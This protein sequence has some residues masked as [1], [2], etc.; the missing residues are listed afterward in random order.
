[1]TRKEVQR[2][3]LLRARDL[4][5][6]EVEST[7]LP[8]EVKLELIRMAGRMTPSPEILIRLGDPDQVQERF[9]TQ[10]EEASTLKIAWLKD[11]LEWRLCLAVLRDKYRQT[12]CVGCYDERYNQKSDGPPPDAPTDGSGCWNLASIRKIKGQY[13][14]SLYH[15]PKHSR[16]E[17]DG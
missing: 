15:L 4:L 14:C 12:V 1:M 2:I 16:E 13:V 5:V 7:A 9:I 3:A 10:A 17:N 11:Y 8:T 6:N